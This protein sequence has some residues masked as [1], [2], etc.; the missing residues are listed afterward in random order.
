MARLF[1]AAVMA[2]VLSVGLFASCAGGEINTVPTD[3]GVDGDSDE[4]CPGGCPE[5]EICYNG[6]CVDPSVPCE[7]VTCPEGQRCYL[8]ECIVGNPCEG[9]VCPNPGDV[10]QN[11]ECVAGEAD[12]DGDD[13]VAR[14]DCNDNDPEIHPG[15]EER[16]NGL[17]DD[18]DD[19][20]DETFDLDGDGFPGC[21]ESPPNLQDCNDDSAWVHPG[22]EERCNA[23]DDN[24]DG[25]VDEGDPGGGEACGEGTGAC[26]L[27]TSQC[28]E[29][30]IECVGAIWPRDE[31][32]NGAD[33]DCNG[34]VD[35]GGATEGC[36]ALPQG[37]VNCVG[38]ACRLTGCDD[39]WANL[40]SNEAD[41]CET[42]LDPYPDSC[43]S[44]HDV[45][46]IS[47]DGS[48]ID[49][50]GTIAPAGDNDWITVM[51]ADSGDS[52]CDAF[53]LTIEFT[54]NPGDAFAMEVR[55][56]GCGQAAEC[57]DPSLGSY[58]FYTDFYLDG[59]WGTEIR[60]ECPCSSGATSPGTAQCTDN[61]S[62]YMIRVFRPEGG[63]AVDEYTLSISN[64]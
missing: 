39:G 58:E 47:D 49:V 54:T 27:G 22:A 51:A 10:C 55:R 42:P 6:G 15:A 8:G 23:E 24:C 62:P 9:V 29:G 31:V 2:L 7:G 25:E 3:G 41:G 4:R 36:A 45:G 40:N 17:D 18:C 56:G 37:V 32:C 21:E 48:D 30:E 46:S 61:S 60:G 13:V 16:C 34:T 35:D 33:D 50:V 11:G 63:Y 26:E 59:P 19:A 64:G 44:A 28:V 57:G 1:I 38:G 12:V 43:G 20:I 5:G 14:D 52:S 53:H